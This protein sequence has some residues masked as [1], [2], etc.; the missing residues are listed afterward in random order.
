MSSR[1]QGYHCH[2]DFQLIFSSAD[3]VSL[4]NFGQIIVTLKYY[5]Q[6]NTD[7]HMAS[8]GNQGAVSQE[9][10]GQL[11]LSGVSLSVESEESP[12]QT[13]QQDDEMKPPAETE[14][15][16]INFCNQNVFSK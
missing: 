9:S 12:H 7:S 6:I 1:G 14:V 16:I 13:V 3:M 11:T 2:G 5:S 4:I 10:T 15:L 8:T